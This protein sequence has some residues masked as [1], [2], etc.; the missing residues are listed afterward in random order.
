MCTSLVK[1]NNNLNNIIFWFR[2]NWYNETWL[3]YI[4]YI[5]T[6]LHFISYKYIFGIP[7]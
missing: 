7:T 5:Y 6:L 1:N 4:I 2:S 3:N